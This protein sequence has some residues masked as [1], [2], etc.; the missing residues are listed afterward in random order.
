MVK[1]PPDNTEDVRDFVSE[2]TGISI[3]KPVVI[4]DIGYLKS[5]AAFLLLK[6]VEESK[7]PI[8]LLST[9]DNVSS[10]LLSRVKRVL[11]F[12]VNENTNNTL[13]S[14][15]DAFNILYG[16]EG[17]PIDKVEFLAENCP[18]LYKLEHDIPYSKY[19]NSVIEILGGKK[20]LELMLQ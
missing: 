16:D 2:Y 18:L 9:N 11:K 14:V 5:T 6:Y 8:I 19:R 20:W 15:K 7:S 10:I 4:S 3:P 12:P 1:N 17:K 13:M